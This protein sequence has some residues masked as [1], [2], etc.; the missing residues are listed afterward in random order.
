MVW[1]VISYGVKL[2]GWKEREGIERLN[3]R[4]VRWVLGVDKRTPGYMLREEI[5]KNKLKGRAGLTA[6]GFKKRLLEDGGSE[7]ARKC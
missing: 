5:Q 4:Y 3:K 6:E 1:S 2:W 7:L